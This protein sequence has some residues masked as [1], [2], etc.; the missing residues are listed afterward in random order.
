MSD[1]KIANSMLGFRRLTSSPGLLGSLGSRIP[2]ENLFWL[3]HLEATTVALDRNILKSSAGFDEA[4]NLLIVGNMVLLQTY[5]PVKSQESKIKV[6]TTEVLT[7][8]RSIRTYGDTGWHN[9]STRLTVNLV[10]EIGNILAK[11]I[12]S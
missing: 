4:E 3:K 8:V 12:F 11:I 2:P 6:K 1:L 7:T 5:I 10:A 9:E